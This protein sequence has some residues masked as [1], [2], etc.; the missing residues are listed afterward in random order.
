M[1]F[2]LLLAGLVSL[3]LGSEMVISG[4]LNIAERH[5]ISQL[6]IGLTILAF[7]TDLPELFVVINGAIQ[8][9]QGTDTSGLIVGETIGSCISQITLVFGIAS[10]FGVFI[11]T[12]NQLRRDGFMMIASV[13]LIFI[14]GLDGVITNTEGLILVIVYVFY[15]GSLFREEKLF[16][17][18]RAPQYN[19][20]WAALSLLSGFVLLIIGSYLTLENAVTISIN[21]GIEQHLVGILLVGLGT[22]L[23]ELATTITALRRNAGTMAAGNLLGSNIFDALFTLGIG[24]AISGFY[25]SNELQYFDLPILFVISILFVVMFSFT[26]RISKKG[27]LFLVGIY[28]LYFLVRVSG[29]LF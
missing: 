4:A 3:W 27:G 18:M 13:V 20:L 6:F 15:F 8:K 11:L 24:S 21:F 28:G 12:K 19:F 26:L 29:I 2:V 22:S 1:E 17:K 16:Q 25:V 23:P 7:G 9:L 14:A 10:F 5:K